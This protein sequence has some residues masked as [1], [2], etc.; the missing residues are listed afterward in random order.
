MC[1][2]WMGRGLVEACDSVIEACDSAASQDTSAASYYCV[3][4]TPSDDK[5]SSGTSIISCSLCLAQV[6][7]ASLLQVI[8]FCN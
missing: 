1:A 4:H 5:L 8:L 3:V 6:T 2:T 7:N